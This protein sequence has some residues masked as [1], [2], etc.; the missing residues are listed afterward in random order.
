MYIFQWIMVW[1]CSQLGHGILHC[2]RRT[3]KA[4]PITS[5]SRNNLI[6]WMRSSSIRNNLCPMCM[7]PPSLISVPALGEGFTLVDV[8]S[9]CWLFYLGPNSNVDYIL[10]V[11]MILKWLWLWVNYIFWKKNVQKLT[12]ADFKSSFSVFLLVLNEPFIL[13]K[14]IWIKFFYYLTWEVIWC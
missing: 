10:F 8:C 7:S 13:F 2:G 5:G 12:V 3:H 6:I 9:C 4:L 11:L 1:I 14:V